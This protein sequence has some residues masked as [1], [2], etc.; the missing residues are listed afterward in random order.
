MTTEV[1]ESGSATIADQPSTGIASI[2]PELLAI[3]F[4][5]T[6][7]DDSK[8]PRHKLPFEVILSH[9]S[10]HWRTVAITTPVL[11]TTIAIYSSRSDC[12]A[13]YFQRSGSQL[14]LDIR[15]DI[16]NADRHSGKYWWLRGDGLVKSVVKTLLPHIHRA[17]SLLVLCCFETTI[18]A[19]LSRFN[20]SVAPHLQRLR[21]NIG[22]PT[23]SLF[24]IRP[25]AFSTKSLPQL[26]FLETD[27]HSCIPLTLKNL[28]TLHLHMLTPLSYSSYQSFAAMLT[29]PSSLRNL[30]IQG[31]LDVTNSLLSG[32]EPGLSFN[33]LKALRLSDGEGLF[34]ATLLLAISAPNLESLWLGSSYKKYGRFFNAPSMVAQRVKFPVLKYLTMSFYDFPYCL[35]FSTVFPNITHLYL[36]CANYYRD[37][38]LFETVLTSHW[39]HLDTFAT[40]SLRQSQMPIIHSALSKILPL[41]RNAG[42]PI[43]QILLDDDLRML[44]RKKFHDVL[45]NVKID[46]LSL[47]TYQEPW[48]VMSH[49]RHIDHP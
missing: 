38:T 25:Q 39:R 48:W 16:Y 40:A 30:C 29:A 9:V 49:E 35:E 32:N 31:S 4:E 28:T 6:L 17:R 1:A 45:P 34:A 20:N 22:H 23:S 24:S 26:T 14:L 21:L 13:N 3:I 10:S 36:P 41:R 15:I 2:P 47:E 37:H 11:W 27:V 44:F 33:H 12:A 8:R 7:S 18:L 19:L 5:M 46:K 42:Y 43:R